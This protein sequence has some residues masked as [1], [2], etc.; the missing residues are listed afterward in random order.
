MEGQVSIISVSYNT[1][2]ALFEMITAALAQTHATELILVNN[3]NPP[4]VVRRLQEM[5]GKE[6]RLKLISGHGNIGF[7]AGCNLGAREAKSE[8]LMFLNPDC[9]PPREMAEKLIEESRKQ[10]GLH[11]IGPRMLEK[12]GKEQ[13][14]SR[15]AMLTPW[16]AFVEA[17][18]LHRL[19]PNHPYCARFKWHEQEVPRETVPVPA[20]S[21]ALM[22]MRKEHYDVLG[23]MDEGYFLHVDDLDLCLR[24]SRAGGA[25]LFMPAPAA[26][27]YGSTSKAPSIVVEWH[28]TK[29]FVRYFFKNFSD[30]Y[31]RF[32][33]WG[34]S[35]A[36][37][38]RFGVRAIFSL[39]PFRKAERSA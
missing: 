6:P 2:P 27:H 11:L 14:G 10:S 39:L 19:F 24:V 20:V 28:K 4:E 8:Y 5:A 35:G 15:R 7:A 18:G 29:S 26:M 23:G 38:A 37:W 32:F 16:T 33:L 36:V 30:T 34:V 22:F 3:G 9:V 12:S 17:F 21:G 1:G 31:P 13:S 25:V